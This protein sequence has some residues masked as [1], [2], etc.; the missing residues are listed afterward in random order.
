MKSNPDEF[1]KLVVPDRF[2]HGPDIIVVRILY[3]GQEFHSLIFLIVLTFHNF[4]DQLIR[5]IQKD[6]A[7]LFLYCSGYIWPGNEDIVRQIRSTGDNLEGTRFEIFFIDPQLEELVICGGKSSNIASL[8][9]FP[10][11]LD[12]CMNDFNINTA[13]CGFNP[14]RPMS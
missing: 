12:A 6:I 14:C 9:G 2:V 5:M 8:Q 7:N 4:A 3:P 10:A 13:S 11:K 1:C